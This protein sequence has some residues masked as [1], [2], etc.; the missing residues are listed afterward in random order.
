MCKHCARGLCPAC[1]VDGRAG[2]SC[3]GACAEEL[4]LQ[5]SI[6]HAAKPNLSQARATLKRTTWLLLVCGGAMLV[7]GIGTDQTLATTM[8]AIFLVFGIAG[9]HLARKVPKP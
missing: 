9:A 5:H 3:G 6:L 7:L 1:A 8:G 4:D 2:I